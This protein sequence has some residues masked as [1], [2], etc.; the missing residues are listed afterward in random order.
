[1]KFASGIRIH[2]LFGLITG[3]LLLVV[4]QARREPQ[5]TFTDVVRMAEEKSAHKP[6]PLV[7]V[8]PEFLRLNYD[9]Y[10]DIRWKND[11]SLWRA[12][13]SPFQIR[14]FHPGYIFN[15]LVEMFVLP[16]SPDQPI[17]Y[18]PEFFDYGKNVFPEKLPKAGGYAGFRVHYPLNQPGVLD[19]LCVFLGASYFRAVPKDLKYGVSARG[20]ALE[21]YVP[22]KVEEFPVFTKFWLEK[23]DSFAK[24]FHLMALLESESVT[25]A[26]RF[27]VIP[28]V[29]TRTDVEAVLYFRQTPKMIGYAPLSS[30]FWFGE[31]TSNTFGDF[32]PEVH[33]SDGVLLQ[34]ENGEWV[35]RPLTWGRQIQ[36]NLFSDTNPK[37]F[38]LLQRDRDFS[39]YQDLEALYHLRPSVWVR[40]LEGFNA[41]SL[42][43][44]QL[45]T[46]N[47]YADN[48]TLF[49]KPDAAPVPNQPHR[50]RYEIRWYRDAEDLSPIGKCLS[51]RVD[52]QEKENQR[53][54]YL[55]FGGGS[56]KNFKADHPPNWEAY[57]PSGAK[58]SK[59]QLLWNEY[60]NSWRFSFVATKQPG[61][62]PQEI[63]CRLTGP[64]GHLTETW[65]YTWLP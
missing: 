6:E 65:S 60:N 31:N 47:E 15:R 19:E 8:A 54:F 53:H 28:G 34:K 10:R 52:D 38:G 64:T 48:V 16:D 32:R 1:M 37:G 51:T 4:I 13:G 23:P 46:K 43:L 18:S 61:Q 40:P 27:R 20:L 9:Q 11:R 55:E 58:I 35:W 14:F 50:I 7:N 41:G 36:T 24:E 39:H 22:G 26:Y 30:M 49:W 29:E 17:R 12:E 21:T 63:L 33:D 59:P 25:G 45:P 57:S 44:M 62:K 5:F 56:L 2:L 42:F 3:I